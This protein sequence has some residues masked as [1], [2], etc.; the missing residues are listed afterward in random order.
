MHFFARHT[1]SVLV[2]LNHASFQP[3]RVFSL[4]VLVLTHER[5]TPQE[6]EP[7]LAWNLRPCRPL[8]LHGRTAALE[9]ACGTWETVYWFWKDRVC[10]LSVFFSLVSGDAIFCSGR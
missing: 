1:Y 6:Y 3:G 5:A 7:Y 10:G 2:L 4:E 9:P 8:V